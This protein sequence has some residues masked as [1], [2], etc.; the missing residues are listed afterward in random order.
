[1][2]NLILLNIKF[3]LHNYNLLYFEKK[4]VSKKFIKIYRYKKKFFKKIHIFMKIKSMNCIDNFYFYI[5]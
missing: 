3:F 5:F 2:Q 4:Y 1:M